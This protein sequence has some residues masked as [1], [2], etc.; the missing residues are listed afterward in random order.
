MK[1]ALSIITAAALILS[2]GILFASCGTKNAE[3]STEPSESVSIPEIITT[4][5][6]CELYDSLEALSEAVGFEINVPK[7]IKPTEYAVV[8]G[9]VAEVRFDGGYL[10]KSLPGGDISNDYTQYE[11][12]VARNVDELVVTLKGN[13][14]KAN[15]AVW[16]TLDYGYSYCIRVFDGVSEQQMTDYIK[17]FK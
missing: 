3:E 13:G 17:Q 1:K 4:T 10:R 2:A 6:P 15:L 12:S 7:G 8:S 11:K 14:D 16:S 9:S 5:E